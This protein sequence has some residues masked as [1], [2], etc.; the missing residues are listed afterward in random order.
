MDLLQNL[1][2]AGGPDE[3]LRFLVV[4]LQVFLD[5]VD[6]F[7]NAAKNAPADPFLAQFSKPTLDQVQPGGTGRCGMEVESPVLAEPAFHP[8]MGVRGVVVDEQ[9]QVQ[10]GVVCRLMLRRNF[11]NS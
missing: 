1:L 11:K 7:G 4:V 5:G 9:R 3:R 10:E 6:E 8:R 2:N